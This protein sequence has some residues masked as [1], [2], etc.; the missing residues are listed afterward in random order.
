MRH[1]LAGC[2]LVGVV[3]G[4]GSAEE[5]P[6]AAAPAGTPAATAPTSAP[7]ASTPEAST[8]PSVSP[9][10]SPSPSPTKKRKATSRVRD[11]FDGD[12]LLRV[13]RP[14]TIRLN[15]KKFYYRQFH[16]LDVGKSSI[17]YLVEYPHGGGAQATLG[18]GGTSSF[19]FRKR[20]TVEVSLVSV[21]KGRALVSITAGKP[22]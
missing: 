1:V 12:C 7:P 9:T 5:P 20:P 4:C 2:V 6:T 16:I 8:T 21:K 11:C 14:V 3:A 18:K 13:S 22:G 10:P 19:G 15:A 17:T